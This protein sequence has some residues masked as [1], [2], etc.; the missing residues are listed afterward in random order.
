M[1]KI[2]VIDDSVAVV[3]LMERIL[4]EDEHEVFT[5]SSGKDGEAILSS[6]PLDLVIT[7]IYMPDVDGLELIRMARRVKPGLRI[8][9]MSSATGKYAILPVAKALGASG[10]LMKPFSRGELKDAVRTCLR[11]M[12]VSEKKSA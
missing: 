7:D 3:E 5:A 12:A 9:A 8:L 1:A 10:T 6:H 11:Q 4:S 2:L